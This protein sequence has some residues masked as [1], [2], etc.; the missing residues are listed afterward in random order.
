VSAGAGR[1]TLGATQL[2]LEGAAIDLKSFVFDHGQMR[3]AGAV[4]G[5]SVARFL[6]I[7]QA[8][9][10]QRSPVRTDVVLDADW[11]FSLGANS[12]GYLQVKRR[13][14]DV[15]IETGAASHRSG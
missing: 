9:T 7:R 15:T 6:E 2:T 11:D 14:G 4:R 8:L 1:V 10:G 5:A 13:G 3:S 12:T